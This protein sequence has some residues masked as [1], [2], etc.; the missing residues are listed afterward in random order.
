MKDDKLGG[1]CD[2]HG[3]KEKY[4]QGLVISHEGKRQLGRYSVGK[5]LY[6]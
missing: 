5:R 3:V 1:A 4:I 2:F 6:E